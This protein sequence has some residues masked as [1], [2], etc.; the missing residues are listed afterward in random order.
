MMKRMMIKSG[1]AS[2]ALVAALTSSALAQDATDILNEQLQLGDVF[3]H[4]D[5]VVETYM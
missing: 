3:G 4:M 1:V 2:M 5:V